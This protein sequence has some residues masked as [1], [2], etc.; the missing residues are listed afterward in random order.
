M[1]NAFELIFICFHYK[2]FSQLAGN[3]MHA[4]I[5]PADI[6]L[7]ALQPVQPAGWEYMHAPTVPADIYPSLLQVVQPSSWEYYV[8]CCATTALDRYPLHL[9][10]IHYIQ[11]MTSSIYV[12]LLSMIH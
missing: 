1:L 10:K 8:L 7:C 4:P 3:V 5:V 12:E 2:Q 9:D 11:M 6:Y